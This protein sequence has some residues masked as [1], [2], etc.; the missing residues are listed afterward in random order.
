MSFNSH[1]QSVSVT[2]EPL[3][4]RNIDVQGYLRSDGLWEVEA[5]MRDTKHYDFTLRDRGL[6]PVGEYLHDMTMALAVDDRLVIREVRA[7]MRA[8]PYRDCG[9]A[10]PRYDLLVGMK[11][12]GGWMNE[13]KEKLGRSTSCT[14]LTELLPVLATAAF[15]TIQGYRLEH[16]RAHAAS[17]KNR[18]HMQNTCFGYREGGRAD[19]LLWKSAE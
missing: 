14:H 18:K 13:V 12:R 9:G 6:L 17:P 19:Q 10:E 4:R 3:H 7:D 15:Q 2:R 8:T 16:D 1:P 5:V 11:I